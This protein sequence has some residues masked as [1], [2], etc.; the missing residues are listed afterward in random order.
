MR[1]LKNYAT[2]LATTVA[3]LGCQTVPKEKLDTVVPIVG[4][5]KTLASQKKELNQLVT[6]RANLV[7]IVKQEDGTFTY[8]RTSNLVQDVAL[9]ENNRRLF[10]LETDRDRDKFISPG[11]MKR[12]REGIYQFQRSLEAIKGQ[13][14]EVQGSNPRVVMDINRIVALQVSRTRINLSYPTAI[15]DL[16]K[17]SKAL[18]H[19]LKAVDRNHDE[20]I[21]SEETKKFLVSH[22][23]RVGMVVPNYLSPLKVSLRDKIVES[24]PRTL[25]VRTPKKTVKE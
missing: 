17:Q 10:F 21:S 20:V 24:E 18:K 2:G 25:Q 3:L 22:R 16:D 8:E 15:V 9:L 7:R 11:E 19:T 1:K 13:N 6:A 14:Y 5:Y 4:E 12:T 23:Q